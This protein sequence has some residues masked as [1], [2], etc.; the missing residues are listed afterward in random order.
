[1]QPTLFR[2]TVRPVYNTLYARME[3]TA[4]QGE[5]VVTRADWRYIKSIKNAITGLMG[6]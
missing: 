6:L 1:M 4:C 2:Y 3:I 5:I